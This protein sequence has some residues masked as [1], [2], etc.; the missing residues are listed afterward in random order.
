M[1][2]LETAAELT[3]FARLLPGI[4]TVLKSAIDAG[5]ELE[6]ADV[7]KELVELSR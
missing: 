4:M 5:D 2:F 1:V 6:A 3:A 7:L